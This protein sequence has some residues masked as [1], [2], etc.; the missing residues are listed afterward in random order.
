MSVNTLRWPSCAGLP[1]LDMN[2]IW[3]AAGEGTS[4][5]LRCVLLNK[6]WQSIQLSFQILMLGK[7]D[8]DHPLGCK[9]MFDLTS[10][11]EIDSCTGSF[12]VLIWLYSGHPG[13]H[14]DHLLRY[15]YLV[16]MSMNLYVNSIIIIICWNNAFLAV[17]LTK[18]WKPFTLLNPSLFE[19]NVMKELH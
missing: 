10:W 8:E 2:Y 1:G 16:E 17:S 4:N 15:Y 9:M 7:H 14:T 12:S 19:L 18:D 3:A 11:L 13:N 5:E 6:H